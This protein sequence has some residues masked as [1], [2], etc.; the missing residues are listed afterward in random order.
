MS[1][2]ENTIQYYWNFLSGNL[3]NS[4]PVLG[5]NV[6]YDIKMLFQ[7]YHI[8]EKENQSFFNASIV[9]DVMQL[10][11]EYFKTSKYMSLKDA[12]IKAGLEFNDAKAHGSTYDTL[13][14]IKLFKKIME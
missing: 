2:R 14:T 13:M 11:K 9:I 3:L 6:F 7:S 8:W 12:C 5:Y 10:A 4:K 1:Q